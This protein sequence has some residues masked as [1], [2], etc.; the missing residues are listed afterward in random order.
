MS[1]VSGSDTL[2]TWNNKNIV[3]DYAASTGLSPG[4][5]RIL[6]EAWPSIRHGDV[7][8][9]GVGAG[10]TI[11]Y[12]SVGAS[13]YVAIDLSRG[14]VNEARRRFPGVD[15]RL[16]DARNLDFNVSDFSFVFFSFNGIDYIHPDERETVFKGIHRVLRAGGLFAFSTHNLNTFKGRSPHFERQLPRLTWDPSRFLIRSVRTSLS[17]IRARRNFERL[18]DRQFIKESVAFIN[19][20]SY[21]CAQLTCYV[22]PKAQAAE[23]ERIGFSAPLVLIGQDGKAITVADTEPWPYFLVRKLLA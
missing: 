22:D 6:A 18:K 20:G 2:Q 3:R 5:T 12:L 14:M 19:D 10:R 1:K 23:L 11:P 8:D 16:G 7:L 21:E 15:V 9:I 13:R 4:E 17:N